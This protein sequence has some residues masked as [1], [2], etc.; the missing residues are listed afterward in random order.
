MGP[1]S[2]N[3]PARTQ[4]G[5][6]VAESVAADIRERV[7]RGEFEGTLPK[8]EL[9]MAEFGVSAPSIREALRILDAEGIITVR[10]GKLGGAEP[11]KPGASSAAFAIGMALQG[12]QVAMSD[13]AESILELEPH[14]ARLVASSPDRAKTVVPELEKNLE[15][16][17]EQ[18]DHPAEF[19]HTSREFHEILLDFVPNL[20]TRLL[21]KSVAKVWTIQEETWASAQSSQGSY[22]TREERELV[23]KTHRK[24]VD[25]L[26]D[27]DGDA[28]Q[29]L[30]RD[31]VGATQSVVL[32]SMGSQTVDASSPR[33]VQA[34]K[35]LR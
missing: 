33:A 26:N 14:C 32:S 12:E 4:F 24:I 7:L 2:A 30:M 27:G 15:L 31:H 10:R 35:A 19:T 17:T 13:L 34:F 6:R 18:L 22:P 20:T 29:N 8:Q 11:R 23:V 9:L 5:Q 21:T 28:A 3:R 16:A 25:K 1:Y